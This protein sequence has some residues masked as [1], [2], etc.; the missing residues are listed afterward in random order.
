MAKE[1][2]T[3][4]QRKGDLVS[5]KYAKIRLEEHMGKESPINLVIV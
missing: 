2:N 1:K 3:N 5:I 4:N